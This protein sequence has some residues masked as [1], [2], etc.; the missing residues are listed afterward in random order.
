M[1]TPPSIKRFYAE[2]YKDAPTWFK[3]RFLNTLNLFSFPVYTALNGDIDESNLNIQYFTFTLVG[4]S[5]ATNNVVS[6]QSTIQGQVHG[7]TLMS[8]VI[9]G[10]AT[11]TY[12]TA[13]PAIASWTISGT[14]L[15]IQSIAGLSDNVTY[16]ITVKVE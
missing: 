14:T 7:I 11:P 1:A 3:T 9:T 10:V 16:K 2:D 15:T 12:L 5:T 4:S 6:F 8:A 13:A